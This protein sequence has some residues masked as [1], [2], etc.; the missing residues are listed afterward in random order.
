MKPMIDEERVRAGLRGA[1]KAFPIYRIKVQWS[2]A[3]PPGA[4][5]RIQRVGRPPLPEGRFWN[6]TSWDVMEREERPVGEIVE[7]RRRKWWPE[8][9]EHKKLLETGDLTITVTLLG[10]DVWCAGWFSH[11]TF[12]VGLSDREVLE[13]FERY[14]DRIQLSDWSETE[15]GGTLMGAEDRY[16]WHGCA[17]GDPQGE[18]TEAPCRCPACKKNGIVRIDH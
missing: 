5:E 15:K 13:S 2:E 4:E 10:R 17:D 6:G 12:D 14:V 9:V 3:Y 16:R 11:W 8:Y 18:R 1:E 7:E